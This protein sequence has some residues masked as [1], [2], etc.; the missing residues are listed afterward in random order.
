VVVLAAGDKFEV[1]ARN[2]LKERIIATPVLV[3]GVI[4]VGTDR[5][6]YAFAEG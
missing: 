6:L 2:E 1:L 4:Y 5:V 3:D